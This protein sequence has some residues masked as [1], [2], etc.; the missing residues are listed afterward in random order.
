MESL[1]LAL[2][3]VGTLVLL[4]LPACASES[5]TPSDFTESGSIEA[6]AELPFVSN[7]QLGMF[8]YVHS[9]SVTPPDA[10]NA[11]DW[12]PDIPFGA[13][14]GA[15]APGG[16]V[17]MHRYT[18]AFTGYGVSMLSELTP[19]YRERHIETLDGMVQKLLNPLVWDYWMRGDELGFD[20][21]GENPIHPYNI[22]YTGHLQLLMAFYERQA[23]DRK[24]IDNDVELTTGDGSKTWTTNLEALSRDIHQQS[25]ANKDTN[26][27]NFYSVSCET[28]WVFT[29]CNTIAQLAF[30]I[31]PESI[32]LDA[33][34][35]NSSF[36]E[37]H[38]EHMLEPETKYYYNRFK[39]YEAVP[40]F[41]TKLPG[42]Y[43]AWAHHFM[44]GFAPEFVEQHYPTFIENAVELVE[45][46]V[47]IVSFGP[48]RG[49]A[50]EDLTLVTA[51]SIDRY[52]PC[53]WSSR[54]GSRYGPR[55][56]LLRTTFGPS[57]RIRVAPSST[58]SRSCDTS[59]TATR[60]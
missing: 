4:M 2:F 19:A 38:G 58:R 42:A 31:L 25:L 50:F 36:V 22:M 5:E 8:N 1:K 39:P 49:G 11:A 56:R 28:P 15:G 30:A 33:K 37:W 59:Q 45:P 57:W 23:G 27:E 3:T 17:N 35:A 54:T 24:Y 34:A 12:G 47:G 21:G 26:G 13:A 46:G 14:A 29:C 44:H 43:S 41:D 20:W 55:L 40:E 51:S 52:G 10:I 60:S 7:E 48:N 16:A 32:D 9:I 53:S 18:I 6:F